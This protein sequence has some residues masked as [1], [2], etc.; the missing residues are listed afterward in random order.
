[1]IVNIW[2]SGENPPIYQNQARLLR[3]I[4]DAEADNVTVHE[5]IEED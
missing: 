2:G 5:L 4:A 1:M 3:S